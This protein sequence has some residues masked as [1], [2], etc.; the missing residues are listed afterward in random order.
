MAGV[1]QVEVSGDEAAWLAGETDTLT[2]AE[3]V[4][5]GHTLAVKTS[6]ETFVGE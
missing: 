4:I 6:V 3:A 5:L 2:V 1:A